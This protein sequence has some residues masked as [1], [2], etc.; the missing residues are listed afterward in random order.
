MA[1]SANAWSAE[2]K[3]K[4]IRVIKKRELFDFSRFIYLLALFNFIAFFYCK[5]PSRK[6]RRIV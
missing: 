6:I 4:K 2:P 5:S 3:L 1:L